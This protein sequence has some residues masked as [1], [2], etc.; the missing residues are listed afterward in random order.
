[1]K[2][3]IQFL[4]FTLLTIN[5]LSAQDYLPV[6]PD[7]TAAPEACYEFFELESVPAFPGGEAGVMQFLSANIQYPKKA[8]D[9]NIQATVVA[10]FIVERDGSIS[11]VEIK[12]DL[13]GLF[14]DE[15]RRVL[16][17]MPK[18]QPGMVNEKPVRVR[19]T[20]PVRFKL[21]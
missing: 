13:G 5:T 4:F 9:N 15:V 18:W 20:L 21:S 1:M 7:S 16:A 8:Q 6:T 10:T 12:R 3:Q 2:T 17:L 14:G 11:G 19:Y